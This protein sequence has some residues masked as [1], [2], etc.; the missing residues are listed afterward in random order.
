MIK[1]ARVREKVKKAAS[2]GHIKSAEDVTRTA[3]AVAK[4][5]RDPEA[6]INISVSLVGHEIGLRSTTELMEKLAPWGWAVRQAHSWPEFEQTFTRLQVAMD[7]IRVAKQPRIT[8]YA[9][10][11]AQQGGSMLGLPPTEGKY[12]AKETTTNES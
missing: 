7:A 1:H 3:F 2:R 10:E 9:A 4:P 11:A 12:D 5:K 6:P 8:D